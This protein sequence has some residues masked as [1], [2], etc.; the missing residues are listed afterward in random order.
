MV[1][2]RSRPESSAES[3]GH[4][5]YLVAWY[6]A[7]RTIDEAAIQQQLRHK[8]PAYMVPV[9]YI[10]LDRFPVTANGKLDTR[11]LPPKLDCA[12]CGSHFLLLN[13]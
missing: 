12:N 8:L 11:A 2:P 10:R 13:R 5:D 1:L 3:L 9:A 4:Y 6:L 7:D